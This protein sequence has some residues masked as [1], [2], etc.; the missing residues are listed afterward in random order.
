MSYQGNVING[1]VVL[2][3]VENFK[4]S[5]QEYENKASSETISPQGLNIAR[6]PVRFFWGCIGPWEGIS[7]PKDAGSNKVTIPYAPLTNFSTWEQS[8]IQ[9]A[10]QELSTKVPALNFVKRNDG[11]AISFQKEASGCWSKLGYQND[12]VVLLERQPLNIGSGCWVKG[13][14]QHEIMHA[15]GMAHEHMRPDR[16]N[17]LIMNTPNMKQLGLDN[18]WKY[19][20]NDVLT[21]FTTSFDYGSLM[22]YPLRVTDSNFVYDT[23]QPFMTATQVVPNGVIVGQRNGPSTLDIPALNLRYPSN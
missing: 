10:I 14:I 8:L 7:W 2:D 15:L 22:M 4:K 18:S 6:C 17:Y 12:G 20:Q 23:N 13:V 9:E 16:D 21:Q 3:T 1:D 11:R 5:I 19:W